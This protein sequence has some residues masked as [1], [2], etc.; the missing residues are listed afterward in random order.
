[1]NIFATHPDPVQ[2]AES[3]RHD[4]KRL[5]KMILESV[6]LLSTVARIYG[7]LDA[8]YKPTHVNHPCTRWLAESSANWTWLWN[9]TAMLGRIYVQEKGKV[10]A[11]SLV[12][13][14]FPSIVKFLPVIGLTPFAKVVPKEFSKFEV[15][16]AY[17][18]T[19]QAK[20]TQDEIKKANKKGDKLPCT[21]H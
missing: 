4:P 16:T 3:L 11:S 7:N 9:Y 17:E 21:N 19:L 1:M 8:P 12:F 10:H 14:E 2:A 13:Q 5:G 20:W 15:H 18:W 6:Q